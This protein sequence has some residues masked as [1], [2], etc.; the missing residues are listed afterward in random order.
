M[1]QI[2]IQS[3]LGNRGFA[4]HAHNARLAQLYI[5]HVAKHVANLFFRRVA[6]GLADSPAKIAEDAPNAAVWL[7]LVCS[8]SEQS[9]AASRRLDTWA[10]TAVVLDCAA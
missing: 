10:L 3:V 4:A 6:V 8:R 1:A 5:A 7:S 9:E 2:G